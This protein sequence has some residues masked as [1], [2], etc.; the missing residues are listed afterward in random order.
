M[1]W[2][3]TQKPGVSEC[4]SDSALSDHRVYTHPHTL[5]SLWEIFI[6]ILHYR[7]HYS[8]SAT[9]AR[10]GSLCVHSQF[11]QSS[12]FMH[13]LLSSECSTTTLQNGRDPHPSQTERHNLS[14]SIVHQVFLK[15]TVYVAL[16][17]LCVC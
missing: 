3:L 14:L 12:P 16:S 4:M 15:I 1:T 17:S 9:P 2:L 6:D 13:S 10:K 7:A 8:N 5:I 11:S